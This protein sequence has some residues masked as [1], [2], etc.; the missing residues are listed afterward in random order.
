LSD[1]PQGHTAA[2]KVYGFQNVKENVYHF[3]HDIIGEELISP[4]YFCASIALRL[5]STNRC[6]SEL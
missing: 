5:S 2:R 1:G 4:D 3:P 6:A